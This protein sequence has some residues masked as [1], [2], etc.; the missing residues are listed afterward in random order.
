MKNFKTEMYSFLI[1]STIYF[2]H[3]NQ[4]AGWL[5]FGFALGVFIL[6]LVLKEK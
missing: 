6:S 1:I 5:W 2:N 4:T 3:D